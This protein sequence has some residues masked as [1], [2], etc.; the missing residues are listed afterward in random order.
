MIKSRWRILA[1]SLFIIS[2]AACSADGEHQQ[3]VKSQGQ[4]ATETQSQSGKNMMLVAG[5][6]QD[7]PVNSGAE[8]DSAALLNFYVENKNSA[9]VQMLIWNTPFEQELSAD[10]FTVSLDG[11]AVP[12]LGLKI[13]RGKPVADDFIVVPHGKK[14]ET[15]IDIANYYDLSAPGQYIVALTPSVIGGTVYLNELTPVLAE[16]STMSVEILNK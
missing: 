1:S 9:D 6:S 14:V 8:K 7:S 10:I 5:I 13:K 15:Q 12:Y 16:G 4:K 2:C 11:Q 3:P